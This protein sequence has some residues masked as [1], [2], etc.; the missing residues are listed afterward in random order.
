MS[1][2]AD[3]ACVGQDDAHRRHLSFRHMPDTTLTRW[4]RRATA[5]ASLVVAALLVVGVAPAE[6]LTSAP[7]VPATVRSCRSF[8]ITGSQ[9]AQ[10]PYSSAGILEFQHFEKGVWR[11]GGTE[12]VFS[13]AL[14]FIVRPS[15]GDVMNSVAATT[16]GDQPELLVTANANSGV[17]T[18]DGCVQ[19]ASVTVTDGALYWQSS[20]SDGTSIAFAGSLFQAPFMSNNLMMTVVSSPFELES[21]SGLLQVFYASHYGESV[22][23]GGIYVRRSGGPPELLKAE[24]GKCVSLSAPLVPVSEGVLMTYQVRDATNDTAVHVSRWDADLR[25]QYADQIVCA[26]TGY[27]YQAY[28]IIRCADGSLVLPFVYAKST[29]TGITGPWTLDVALSEDDGASW[30]RLDQPRTIMADA[31]VQAGIMEP[32]AVEV[33]PGDVAI[34]FRCAAGYI[35]RVDLDLGSGT[36]G[37]PYLTNLESPLTGLAVL[38]LDS[39]VIAVAWTAG[40]PQADSPRSPRKVVVLGLSEDGL[41]SFSSIHVICTSESLGDSMVT[42]TPYVHQPRLS[43]IDGVLRIGVNRVATAADIASYVYAQQGPVLVHNVI[44]PD[45]AWHTVQMDPGA[46]RL[47]LLAAFEPASFAA[48]GMIGSQTSWSATTTLPCG[49]RW[50]VRLRAG[51]G[52]SAWTAFAVDRAILTSPALSSG[53]VTFARPSLMTARLTSAAGAPM[54]SMPVQLLR[55]GRVAQTVTS[56][57]DGSLEVKVRSSQVADWCL[58][59]AGNDSIGGVTSTTVRTV[60]KYAM[61]VIVSGAGVGRGKGYLSRGVSYA[62]IATGRFRKALLHGPSNVLVHVA[63]KSARFRAPATGSYSARVEIPGGGTLIVW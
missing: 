17:G 51:S 48:F 46:Q 18:S 22:A 25:T 50:R 43:E 26:Q 20:R 30:V 42:S 28:S 9:Q 29:P 38:K 54:G 52:V 62:V 57:P 13:D 3:V 11:P 19:P 14:P 60:P 8:I 61:R 1:R 6:A 35:G 7:S 32:S 44:R 39:G 31:P 33:E 24:A 5:T 59:F 4:R 47:D 16:T 56:A 2:V 36:L 53:T 58:R 27:V 45:A 12:S 15:L 49:G 10:P 41:K 63:S 40:V 34:L 55:N 21:P 23:A 37:E